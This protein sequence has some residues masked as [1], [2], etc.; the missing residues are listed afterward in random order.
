ME[1]RKDDVS[2]LK[3]LGSKGTE[4]KYDGPSNEMLETFP[5]KFPER[6]YKVQLDVPEFTSLCPKTGQPDFATI[7]ITYV[8]DKLCV[9]TKS[10]KLYMFAWR[11]EGTFMETIVNSIYSDLFYK[12]EPKHLMVMGEFNARG[13]IG[14]VCVAKDESWE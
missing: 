1:D 4:Y 11:S 13:G 12:L 2:G 10:L 9:E 3:N 6:D 8:P 7:T 5:N 14:L